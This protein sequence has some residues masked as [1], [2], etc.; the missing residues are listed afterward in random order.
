M[1]NKHSFRYDLDTLDKVA[2]I[3]MKDLYCLGKEDN[4]LSLVDFSFK[5]KE[6]IAFLHLCNAAH[7]VFNYE[8]KI[9]ANW[10]TFFIYNFKY[11]LKTFCTRIK[12]KDGID[13]ETYI[14]TI[15]EKNNLPLVFTDIFYAYYNNKKVK[16]K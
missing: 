2:D 4:Q 11:K 15:E 8:L 1:T 5:N 12:T 16:E 7:N 9:Y 13:V 6:H 3:V 14:N 10:F